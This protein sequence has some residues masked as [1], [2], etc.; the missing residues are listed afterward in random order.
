MKPQAAHGTGS[1]YASPRSRA[2]GGDKRLW[3]G[4]QGRGAMTSLGAQGPAGWLPLSPHCVSGDPGGRRGAGH[5]EAPSPTMSQGRR[6]PGAEWGETEAHPA[7]A[8]QLRP[9]QGASEQAGGLGSGGQHGPLGHSPTHSLS[10]SVSLFHRG[11]H[12]DPVPCPR[13]HGGWWQNW[14]P[15]SLPWGGDPTPSTQSR[16]AMSRLGSPLHP[17]GTW[18][19]PLW[20]PQPTQ[21]L[22]ACL[23]GTSPRDGPNHPPVCTQ[24]PTSHSRPPA[25]PPAKAPALTR[26][27]GRPCPPSSG[28]PD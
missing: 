25:P 1:P 18:V 28:V 3:P 5:R 20:P 17:P 6:G 21:R 11:R 19:A 12:G 10:L 2:T 27:F 14:E 16:G 23:K 7:A 22:G 8:A 13:P 9:P 24:A 26:A 15:T 4:Q